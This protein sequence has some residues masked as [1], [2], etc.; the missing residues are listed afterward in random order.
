MRYLTGL[1]GIE[2]YLKRIANEAQAPETRRSAAPILKHAKKS[3]RVDELVALAKLNGVSTVRVDLGEI[4]ARVGRGTHRGVMLEVPYG[5]ELVTD[6][7]E[8]LESGIPATCAVVAL[9]GVTDPHNLGAILRSADQ[10]GADLVIVPARRNARINDTVYRT[11]A[12]AAAQVPTVTV[13][14]LTR[15]LGDLKEA[16][17]WVYGADTGGVDVLSAKLDARAVLVM[18]SEGDGMS[19]LVRE[20]CDELVRI[21]SFGSVDSLN[22]SVAAGVLL[23]E[24]RRQQGLFGE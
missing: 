22:V 18:G 5:A 23:Y 13:P 12:G 21:P 15:A 19:R 24:L 2:A 7:R 20:S 9:D 4:D 3:K 6:L 11:S 10:F 8:F 14:N 17:F 1:H 16:G